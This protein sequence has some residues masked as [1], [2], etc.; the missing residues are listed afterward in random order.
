MFVTQETL[1]MLRKTYPAGT[2]VRLLK[3]DDIQAPPIG[4]LGIVN[5]VDDAG[6]IMIRW[7]NGS[8][9]NVVYG[10]DEI[11]TIEEVYLI[12]VDGTLKAW[13]E[14]AGPDLWGKPDYIRTCDDLPNMVEAIKMLIKIVQMPNSKKAL[15]F[16]SASLSDAASAYKKEE[17][18]KMF[19][20]VTLTDDMFIFTP[21]GRSKTEFYEPKG[22]TILTDY[23]PEAIEWVNAGGKAI[24]V[25]NNCNSKHGKWRGNSIHYEQTPESILQL[26][27]ALSSFKEVA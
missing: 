11:E 8:G 1:Q 26:I 18:V 4:M 12:D 9:L 15:R 22:T 27:L 19:E 10:E 5:G 24:K 25:R 21:Y 13:N 16:F 14:E 23:S 17:L 6:N 20:G 3:M 7:E 2:R